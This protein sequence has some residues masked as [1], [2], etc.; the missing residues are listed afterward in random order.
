MHRPSGARSD[1][2]DSRL[3]LVSTTPTINA[4]VQIEE[5]PSNP[6]GKNIVAAK[7]VQPTQTTR[8][9]RLPDTI[10]PGSVQPGR[11]LRGQAPDV[12]RAVHALRPLSRTLLPGTQHHMPSAQKDVQISDIEPHSKR[13][14][15]SS[16]SREI[17]NRSFAKSVRKSFHIADVP[18]IVALTPKFG[19]AHSD[20]GVAFRIQLC[21]RLA[22][23]AQR[24]V[25]KLVG[26]HSRRKERGEVPQRRPS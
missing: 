5:K 13:S 20:L 14:T 8:V 21:A 3:C 18:Q 15:S 9:C 7:V 17:T 1:Q 26:T 25:P 11:T 4:E 10:Q 2:R 23:E 16:V 19:E 24:T 12:F 22:R 6:H